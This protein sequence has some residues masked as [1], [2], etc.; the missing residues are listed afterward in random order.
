[1]PVGKLNSERVVP[2]DPDTVQVIDAWIAQRAGSGRC[3]T[4][5]TAG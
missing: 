5:A 4:P 1:V 2:L 3:P